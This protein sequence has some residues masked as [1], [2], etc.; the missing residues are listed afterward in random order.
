[1]TR[2]QMTDPAFVLPGTMPGIDVAAWGESPCFTGSGRAA[3]ELAEALTSIAD[4]T[5]DAVRDDLRDPAT[6]LLQ[7]RAEKS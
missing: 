4:R 3:P 7:S 6:D 1:M 5:G 2:A